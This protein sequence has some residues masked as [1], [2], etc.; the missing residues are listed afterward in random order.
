MTGFLMFS[1]YG[2][3][4]SKPRLYGIIRTPILRLSYGPVS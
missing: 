3:G 4:R 2:C 1:K